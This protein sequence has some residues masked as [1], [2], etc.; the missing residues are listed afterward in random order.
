MAGPG[1]PGR[2]ETSVLVIEDDAPLRQSMGLALRRLGWSVREAA[3]AASVRRALRED[4]PSVV[5]TDLRICGFEDPGELLRTVTARA[6]GC[7]I[8]VVTA[9][10]T[11]GLRCAAVRAWLQ[12]PCSLE[13]LRSAV[14][15]ALQAASGEEVAPDR[16]DRAG[17]G[18]PPRPPRGHE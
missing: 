5:V 2:P 14:G 18:S 13:R 16:W 1:S 8:V 12:K 17:D 6:A 4:R 10:A 11:T 3:D 7:S 15:E 9:E